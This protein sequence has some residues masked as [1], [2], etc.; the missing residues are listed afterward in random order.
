MTTK[1]AILVILHY[2]INKTKLEGIMT[3]ILGK[4]ILE[5]SK[6]QGISQRELA[7][8]IGVTETT[9]SRYIKG[10]RE[11]KIEILSNLAK[12]L[13]TTV[14]YLIG[15]SIGSDQYGEYPQIKKLIAR[16]SKNLTMAEKRK[17]IDVLLSE[18][19]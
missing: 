4:R 19:E 16:N 14:D 10:T 8:L 17:L 1:I 3:N 2:H 7:T 11:P 5:L 12:V 9:I 15:D 18:E 6:I 13:D